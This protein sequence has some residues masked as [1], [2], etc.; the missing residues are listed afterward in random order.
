[1]LS[2]KILI[3]DDQP[4]ILSLLKEILEIDGYEIVTAHTG[5]EALEVIR[6]HAFH[7]IFLDYWIPVKNGMEV[8]QQL[9]KEKSL[10]P[11]VMMSGLPEKVNE[12][13]KNYSQ[14]VAVLEKP[15]DVNE[16][17]D[18]VEKKIAFDSME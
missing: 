9:E 15:F 3:V 11:I 8:V 14:I 18:L 7:L 2:V 6:K 4:G 12:T 10:I 5:Q 13:I 1:M 17:R 16:V